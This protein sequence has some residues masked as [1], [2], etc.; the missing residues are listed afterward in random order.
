MSRKV[1]PVVLATVLAALLGAGPRSQPA[2]AADPEPAAGAQIVGSW[3]GAKLRCQKEENK[4]VRCGT[5]TSFQIT[6]DEGGHGG[7]PDESLPREFT[8]RWAGNAEIVI[9]PVG[10][11]DEVKIFG[12]EQEDADALTFQAYVYLPTADP[13]APAEARYIHYVFDVTRA[14]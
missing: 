4:L 6:F 9:T 8:W 3:A 11:G 12:L 10:G 7:T 2:P 5:P 13:N 14:P 1:R